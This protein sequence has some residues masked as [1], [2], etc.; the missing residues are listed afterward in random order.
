MRNPILTTCLLALLL[1][2][3]NAS[4]AVICAATSS[5]IRQALAIAGSNGESDTIRIIIGTYS[6]T[7]GAI[8]FPY[9]TEENHALTIEGGYTFGCGVRVDKAA[10]TVLSGSG[11]RQVMRLYSY[12][13]GAVTVRNLTIEDGESDAP[14]AG[15]S[16]EGPTGMFFQGFTGSATVER[17]IFLGNRSAAEAGGLRIANRVGSVAVRGNLL[18]FNR[19]SENHCAVRIES[20]GNSPNTVL[21][22]GNTVALN[23]CNAGASLCD[24]GGAYFSGE[25]HAVIYDNLF[26]FNTD[27]DIRIDDP[28]VDADLYFNNID[29]VFGT[30]GSEVGTLNVANPEFV[31]ALAEDFHLQPTS[32]LRNNGNAPFPLPSVDLDGGPRIIESAPD[33]GA[34]EIPDVLFV[35]GFDGG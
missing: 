15:L 35:D 16:I 18:A 32:P 19:C 20:R 25:Q 10:L 8:A 7:S 34:Y 13:S 5:A 2:A 27:E 1:A 31:D 26:A 29:D 4:A 6:A 3:G 12:S 11:M 28:E 21:F 17:V 24:S 33:L 14:G 22:G 30:P 23:T 9:T